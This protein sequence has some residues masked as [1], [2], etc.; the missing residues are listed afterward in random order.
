[1]PNR[2]AAPWS[3][4]A[5]LGVILLCAAGA[6]AASGCSSGETGL[7]L[8]RPLAELPVGGSDTGATGGSAGSAA[9][10]GTL[11]MAGESSL[12]D[13]GASVFPPEGGAGGAPDVVMPTD[14][15]WI[16]QRCTP[17]IEFSNHDTTET[18]QL[19]TNAVPKP[20]QAMWRATH[21]TCRQLFRD[22]AEVKD[23]PTITLIIENAGGIASTSG[24]TIKLSTPY[25]KQQSDAGVDLTQEIEGILHFATSLIYQNGG[26]ST[27]AAPPRWLLVGIADFVRLESGYIDRATRMPGG[28]Y[29]MSGSQTTAF[30]LDYLATKRSDVVYEL[31]RELA[32][33]S[34]AWSNDVFVK[35]LGSDVD[36]LWA[37]YQSTL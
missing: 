9:S 28:S 21:D 13:G 30:F 18:G 8:G 7:V 14:P 27:D 5:I 37:D 6:S 12:G 23:V 32:P 22:G 11:A 15:P 29:D 35:L 1:M 20:G 2:A 16:G 4:R 25:L 24:T 10:G 33:S 17:T 31:N 3:N 34:P 19:F 36:T 26:S